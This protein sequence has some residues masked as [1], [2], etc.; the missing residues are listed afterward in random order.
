MS[1]V[2]LFSQ[3]EKCCACGACASVCPNDAIRMK[4]D[5]CGFIYPH[6][7]DAKCIKC[8]QCT[9][10]CAFQN[11]PPT[12]TPLKTYAAAAKDDALI[13]QS[14]S[15]GLFSVFALN[16]L[17]QG[18]AVYGTALQLSDA[19]LT[20]RHIRIDSPHQLEI[21]RGSK[22]VQSDMG[23]T[24]RQV[25]KDLAAQRRVLFSGTPCQV[26]GLYAFLGS[27]YDNLLTAEV[28]CHGV[29]SGNMFRDFLS[30][31]RKKLRAKE[32]LSFSFRDKSKGQRSVCRIKYT[33]S[34]GATR[35]KLYG[36]NLLSYI[37]LFYRS[38]ICRPSCYACPYATGKRC[39]DITLGD[40]WGFH[41]EHP[42]L[43][44][45]INLTDAKGVSCLLVNTPKGAA[46]A[47]DIAQSLV[48]LPSEFAK[49]A[50]HNA[51]LCAPVNIPQNREAVLKLYEES[52]YAAVEAYCKKRYK[53]ERI[54]TRI[55]NA[56]PG[57]LR[58]L[59]SK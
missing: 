33:D 39:A 17:R 5:S 13:Q 4:P 12:H 47:E 44:E 32:I 7:E 28:I 26:G 25:K 51:Q 1:T 18:G 27:E 22:Y 59:L 10:V 23:D 20:A 37:L 43:E 53:K 42:Q 16:V 29:P 21:L 54:K 49:A 24:Y 45:G 35:Q 41:A 14:S 2:T 11:A 3:K 19:M 50:R 6:I 31:E 38:A 46:Q 58:S 52:G 57:F 56:L 30:C 48:L 15:G 8:F 9:K 34:H 36:G 55:A 40:Y